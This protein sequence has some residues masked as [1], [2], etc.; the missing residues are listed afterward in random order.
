[1]RLLDRYLLR[2]LLVPLGYCLGGFLIFWIS[3]DLFSE[4]GNMQSH[5]LHASDIAEYYVVKT[6]EFLVVVLPIALLLALLYTLTNH[7][8]HHEITAIRAAGVSLWR[9]CLPYLAVGFMASL[10]LFALDE[11]WV[12]D[13]AERAE[14]ILH[15]REQPAS[16]TPGRNR[17]TNLDFTSSKDGHKRFWHVGVYDNRT[18]EM[19]NPIVDWGQSDGSRCEL[20]ADRAIRVRGG[21]KFY[22]V[23]EFRDS[24]QTKEPLVPFLQTNA[25]A[26]PEFTETPEEIQSEINIS[27]GMSFHNARR[28]DIALTEIFDYLRLHPRLD[29]SADR[30]WL[31]TKLHGRLAAPWTCLVVVLIAIPFGAASGRRNVFVG[32]A[33]S[34]FICFAYFVLMQL[35]LALGTRG[36]LPAWLAAW[37]PN[38]VFGLAG[39]WLTARVR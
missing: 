31:Y 15:R 35:C 26:M 6:P 1:M 38:L 33:G 20:R 22:N 27:K 28:A 23:Q 21:W 39:L 30:F 8:R 17:F 24:G 13:S 3:F 16:G 34:I 25:L 7:A 18:A 19:Q 12:P 2:E 10:A 14:D 29:N 36:T 9:L 5:K 32:V 4:L 37:F 11:L